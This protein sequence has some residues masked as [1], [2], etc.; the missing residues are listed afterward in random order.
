MKWV[1]TVKLSWLWSGLGKHERAEDGDC[2]TVK[3]VK[4][5]T[6]TS[7]FMRKLAVLIIADFP[8]EWSIQYWGTPIS[9]PQQ[10]C[11]S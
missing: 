4:P 8:R 2:E 6:A 9:V 11:P 5:E 1:E 10:A 7:R 3:I